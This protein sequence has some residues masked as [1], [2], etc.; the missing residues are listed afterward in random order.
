MHVPG[1]NRYATGEH[2]MIGENLHRTVARGGSAIAQ[3][4]EFVVTHGPNAAVGGDEKAVQV[5]AGNHIHA[6]GHELGR[7][8]NLAARSIAQLSLIVSSHTP[9]R[10]ALEEETMKASG[11]NCGDPT[12]E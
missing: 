8:V 1:G 12:V 5:S 2:A 9:Q 6:A 10:I 3:R 4:A 7:A 11:G